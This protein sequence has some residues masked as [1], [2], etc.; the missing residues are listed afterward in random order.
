MSKKTE[1]E[2]REVMRIL[3]MTYLI[4]ANADKFAASVA[5]L[6]TEYTSAVKALQDAN[7][8]S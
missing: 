3:L 1:A 2:K 5:A 6:G 4:I 8:H 7:V